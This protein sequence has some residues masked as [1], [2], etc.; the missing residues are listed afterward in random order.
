MRPGSDF[1]P[2]FLKQLELDRFDVEDDTL[3]LSIQRNEPHDAFDIGLGLGK[4]ENVL[5][6]TPLVGL[7]DL[8]HQWKSVLLRNQF[9][10]AVGLQV[11]R[12]KTQELIFVDWELRVFDDVFAVEI[13]HG[14]E[15]L[16]DL[17]SLRPKQ[18]D[19][20]KLYCRKHKDN[21]C[22]SPSHHHKSTKN[23]WIRL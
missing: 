23:M 11:V 9:D 2:I 18:A 4:E 12:F 10:A 8:F 16:A 3:F 5:H 13:D 1:R 14:G 15:I 17:R 20:A 21:S 19:E 6:R 7:I 22:C